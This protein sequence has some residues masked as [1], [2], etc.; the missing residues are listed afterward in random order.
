MHVS[1][2]EQPERSLADRWI[3][4]LASTSADQIEAVKTQLNVS[5]RGE[6]GGSRSRSQ[7]E[8]KQCTALARRVRVDLPA[9]DDAIGTDG[10]SPKERSVR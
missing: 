7:R 10:C 6:T 3:G 9:S 4:L 5:R 8:A 2:E 1:K